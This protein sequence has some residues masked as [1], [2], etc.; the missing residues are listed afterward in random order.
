[1]TY[2]QTLMRDAEVLMWLS[3]GKGLSAAT[4][5]YFAREFEHANMVLR[6]ETLEAAIAALARS[7]VL[8]RGGW[9]CMVSVA[10]KT[11]PQCISFRGVSGT[12]PGPSEVDG[13][14]VIRK[15][16]STDHLQLAA[17]LTGHLT[18][19]VGSVLGAVGEF[20]LSEDS[21]GPLWLIVVDSVMADK[22]ADLSKL[23]VPQSVW[24]ALAPSNVT[25]ARF[26]ASPSSVSANARFDEG[27][28]P[29][30]DDVD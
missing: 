6:N 11:A 18:E 1:M 22:R 20:A 10:D 2:K 30:V 14:T 9:L 28:T 4:I 25:D 29:H 5:E 3:E 24:K 12:G 26:E 7:S 13:H 19:Y 17:W 27:K 23:V 15:V 16:F 8:E 21:V